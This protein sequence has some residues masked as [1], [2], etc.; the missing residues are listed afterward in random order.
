M[1]NLLTPNALAI[2]VDCS[3][4]DFFW[5]VNENLHKQ[6]LYRNISHDY[7]SCPGAHN[8]SYCNTAVKFQLLF[9]S[10]FFKKEIQG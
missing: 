8:W 7:Y 5:E 6:L 4:E 3:A 10:N 1:L 9:M 2:I